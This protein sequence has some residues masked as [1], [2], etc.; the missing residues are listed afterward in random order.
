MATASFAAG[1]RTARGL[2]A[3]G[4][5]VVNVAVR[6]VPQ[7]GLAPSHVIGSFISAKGNHGRS[8]DYYSEQH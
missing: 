5:V 4:G 8:A 2:L 7:E 3:G 6:T 1:F